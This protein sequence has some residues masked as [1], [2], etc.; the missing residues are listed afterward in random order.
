MTP[1]EYNQCVELY[2]DRVFRFIVKNLKREEESRDIVQNA[3]E[4]LWVKHPHVDFTKARAYLFTTAYRNMIDQIRKAKRMDYVEEIPESGD[5]LHQGQFELKELLNQ[6]LE[7]LSPIQKSVV[8]LRDY[9]GYSYRE[10]GE[11]TGLNES[12]VKVYIFRAR[13]NLQEIISKLE[14]PC[15]S[16]ADDFVSEKMKCISNKKK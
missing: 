3:F 4:I 13:K 2:A 16:F 10:I 8:L 5:A 1:Q 11:V 7:Y 9:E 6:A 12:Q 14:R 15:E